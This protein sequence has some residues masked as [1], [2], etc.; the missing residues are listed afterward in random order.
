MGVAGIVV[1]AVIVA[2]VFFVWGWTRAARYRSEKGRAPWGVSP[3]GWGVIHVA[4]LPIGWALYSAASRTTVVSDPSLAH[5]AA[6]V[7]ADTPEEREKLQQI[8]AQLPFLPPPQPDSRGWH[9]DPLNQKDFRFFD[10][11]RWTREV[12]DNPAQRVAAVVGDERADLDRRLRAL[13]APADVSPSWHLDPLGEHHFRYFDGQR[14]T[15][16][17]REARSS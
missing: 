5:R 15:T 10:G 2:A 12:T 16:D 11:Q 7:I 14:W 3:T 8:V 6:P 1:F 13:P 17:V 4:L 9:E